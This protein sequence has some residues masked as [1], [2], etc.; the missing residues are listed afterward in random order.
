MRFIARFSFLKFMC[1][2]IFIHIV[3]AANLARN[4]CFKLHVSHFIAD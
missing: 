3:E 2:V 4:Y 1:F